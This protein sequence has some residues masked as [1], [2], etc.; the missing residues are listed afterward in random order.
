MSASE[1]AYRILQWARSLVPI[2]TTALLILV[3]E[4]PLPL[5]FYGVAA[6][7][8][9][10]MGVYYW[11]ILRPDLMPRSAVFAVGLLQDFLMGTPLGLSAVIYLLAHAALVT[12][13]RFLVGRPFWIFWWGFAL[14]AL[15]GTVLAW[16]L[17]SLLNGTLIRLPTLVFGLFVTIA[18]FPMI[19]WLMLQAQRATLSAS[20]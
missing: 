3:A 17:V 11:S 20:D 10:L 13:R 19:A 14:V 8:L 12:K 16:A 5:P 9:P 15:A 1:W 7:W 18:A 6:P 2:T 4:L